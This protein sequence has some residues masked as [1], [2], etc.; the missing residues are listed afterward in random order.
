MGQDT[1]SMDGR[2]IYDLHCEWLPKN[3]YKSYFEELSLYF[4]TEYLYITYEKVKLRLNAQSTVD[5]S[6]KSLKRK[7]MKS[8][9]SVRPYID[10][11]FARTG[12]GR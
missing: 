1:R 5:D 11:I 6:A 7:Q 4:Y 3:P 12:G 2:Q 8:L 9:T 10:K